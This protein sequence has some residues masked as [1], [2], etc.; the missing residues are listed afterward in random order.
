MDRVEQGEL[1]QRPHGR[2]LSLASHVAHEGDAGTVNT[3]T[4]STHTSQ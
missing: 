1:M 2:L 4:E 3:D